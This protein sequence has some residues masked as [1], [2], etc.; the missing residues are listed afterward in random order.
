METNVT[1]IADRIYRLSTFVPEIGPTGFTFNQF[2]IDADQPL[3]FHTGPRAM[4]DSVSSVVSSL[5]PLDRLGWVTFGHLEADECGAM[6]QWLAAAPQAQVAHTVVG[7]MTSIADLADRPPRP[8]QDGQ[9]LDLGGKQVRSIDTPHV[10]HGWDAHVMFEETTGTLLCGDILTQIG[11]GPAITANDIIEA[12]GQ[13]E[14]M[15]GATCLT[16]NTAPTIRRLAE[17]RPQTLAIMH[18]SSF[19]GDCHTALLEAAEEYERRHS[20]S[21]RDTPTSL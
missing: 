12:A 16:P 21:T 15:F 13:A 4:F 1:E 10:P 3:L 14:D 5:M 9:V 17:L 7:C 20:E 11:N 6:N 19:N 8:L 2:L 18:G